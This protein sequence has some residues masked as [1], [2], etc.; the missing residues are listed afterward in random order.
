M[1]QRYLNKISGPLLDRINLH[2]EITSVSFDE[3][4]EHKELEKSSVIRQR[5]IQ[6]REL[7]TKRFEEYPGIYCNAQMNNKLLKEICV[8]TS[9]GQTC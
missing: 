7:Q 9:V 8:I 1:V 2:V 5:V 4:A 3:M 6:A